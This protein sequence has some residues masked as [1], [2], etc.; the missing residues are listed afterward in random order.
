M[1]FAGSR[2]NLAERFGGGVAMRLVIALISFVAL[3]LALA[4]LASGPGT[5]FGLWDYG[6]GLTI[7]RKVAEP[8]AIGGVVKLSP[9]FTAAALALLGAFASLFMRA[10]ALALLAL[11]A[12]A[13]AGAGGYV[14]LKMRAMVQANPFIHDVTTDFESPPEILAAANMP[15]KNPPAYAGAELV[16]DTQMTVAQA[17]REAF[18]DIAPFIA[19][20]DLQTTANAVR[21]TISDMRMETLAEGP[22]SGDT[23]SGWRI[24]AVST[25]LWFGFKDDFIVRLTP[26][27]ATQ[28]R[29]DVRSKSR[30]GGSDLGANAARVRAFMEKLDAA[31]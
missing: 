23:G 17:Q 10:W 27:S 13:G 25:S 31:I 4:V 5:R 19:E 8:I 16:R 15:R 11:I 7:I 1:H 3:A 14:P 22:V 24:E 30:V 29:V 26:V 2:D 9:I 20:A 6:T 28:T 21:A 18:P 12:A